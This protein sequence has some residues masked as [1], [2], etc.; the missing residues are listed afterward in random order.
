MPLSY[1]PSASAP[2]SRRVY[3]EIVGTAAAFSKE[4]GLRA[5]PPG[6]S[7]QADVCSG[8]G[9]QA[10]APGL[11]TQGGMFSGGDNADQ[12]PTVCVCP[13]SGAVI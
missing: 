2:S 11:Q 1:R 7:S 8:N 13:L 10:R 4:A 3:P 6:E 9:V 12:L 5:P